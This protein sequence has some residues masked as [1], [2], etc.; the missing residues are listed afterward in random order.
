MAKAAFAGDEATF[1]PLSRFGLLQLALAV[2]H[3]AGGGDAART[4]GRRSLTT[5]AIDIARALRHAML[6]DTATPRFVAR[7]APDEAEAAA[8]LVARLGPRASVKA[9]PAVAPGRFTVE[10]G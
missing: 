4:G 3:T 6:S 2:A 9:D 10:E 1:G 5:R 7:C 8:S